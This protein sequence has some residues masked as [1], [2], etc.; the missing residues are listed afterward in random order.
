[1]NN[2]T[3]NKVRNLRAGIAVDILQ[4]LLVERYQNAENMPKVSLF[5]DNETDLLGKF[6]LFRQSGTPAAISVWTHIMR[7]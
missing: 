3:L 1:M 6:C 5:I 4:R 7:R 2:E